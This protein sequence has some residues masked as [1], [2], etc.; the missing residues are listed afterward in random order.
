MEE[1]GASDRPPLAH[2][3]DAVAVGDH[4]VVEEDLVEVGVPV[5]LDQR[6]DLDA[7]LVHLDGERGD[8][9][10]LGRIGIGARQQEPPLGVVRPAATTPSVP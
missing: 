6:A 5:H 2:L 1:H 3:A 7:G 9:G 4:G 8:A 10:V